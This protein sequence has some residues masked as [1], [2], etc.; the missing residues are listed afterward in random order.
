MN[1]VLIILF[2]ALLI[3]GLYIKFE[4]NQYRNYKWQSKNGW[5]KVVYNDKYVSDSL[6][7]RS[8]RNYSKM[9]GGKVVFKWSV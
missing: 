6:C 9:F 4:K 5:F 3:I 8:A 2:F 7:F 1:A